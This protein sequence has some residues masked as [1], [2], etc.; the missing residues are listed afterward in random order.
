MQ[1]AGWEHLGR[2]SR[3]GESVQ[4]SAPSRRVGKGWGGGGGRG[5]MLPVGR[6]GGRD[7]MLLVGRGGGTGS[8][9]PGG[10]EGGGQGVV[11]GERGEGGSVCSVS[12]FC[13]LL[14]LL[15]QVSKGFSRGKT[16]TQRS[17]TQVPVRVGGKKAC[18]PKRVRKGTWA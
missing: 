18:D 4:C 6:G 5:V 17:C 3:G 12:L 2:G 11:G 13:Q 9:A 10:E 7:V 16:N 14:S 1:A 8:N 15:S